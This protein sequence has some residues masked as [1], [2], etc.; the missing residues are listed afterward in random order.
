[1]GYQCIQVHV[2]DCYPVYAASAMGALIV[3]RRRRAFR[4][5]LC[6]EGYDRLLSEL[7][8]QMREDI[9]FIKLIDRCK[10]CSF[11]YSKAP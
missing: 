5:L 3:F 9:I 7:V 6:K 4:V 1:M 11:T 10:S 2:L 8:C